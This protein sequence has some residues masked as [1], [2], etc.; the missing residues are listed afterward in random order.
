M[1]YIG[2]LRN[3]KTVQPVEFSRED[4]AEDQASKYLIA[5]E[6]R[7]LRAAIFDGM[8]NDAG[9]LEKHPDARERTAMLSGLLDDFVLDLLDEWDPTEI[10][11]WQ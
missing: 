1:S 8:A 10:L 5:A 2:F 7:R 11:P 4:V 9:V 3:L 6:Y